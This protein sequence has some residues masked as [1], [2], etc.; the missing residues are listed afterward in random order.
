M[1]RMRPCSEA[2]TQ[3]SVTFFD[4]AARFASGL[5][6]VPALSCSQRVAFCAKK[7]NALNHGLKTSRSVA[8]T[9]SSVK[10]SGS[11]RTTGELTR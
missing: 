11:A 10:R 8:L 4:A 1:K 7:R 6:L 9:P 3:T 2:C 5:N